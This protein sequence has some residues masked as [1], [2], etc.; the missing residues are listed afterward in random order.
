MPDTKSK[1]VA[2]PTGEKADTITQHELMRLF[3]LRQNYLDARKAYEDEVNSMT[4]RLERGA[5]VE[6]GLHSA[7]LSFEPPQLLIR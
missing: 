1:I 2:F 4:A 3:S 5:E 6:K 7:S